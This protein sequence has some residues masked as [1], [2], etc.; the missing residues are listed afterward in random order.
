MWPDGQERPEGVR[1]EVEEPVLRCQPPHQVAHQLVPWPRCRSAGSDEIVRRLD[2][3]RLAQP[4]RPI[5]EVGGLAHVIIGKGGADEVIHAVTVALAGG[6]GGDGAGVEPVGE[7]VVRALGAL[8][9]GQPLRGVGPVVVARQ[10]EGL[11]TE[12]EAVGG[13][14][15]FRSAAHTGEEGR[16]LCGR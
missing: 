4:V 6:H 16:P 1:V 5:V 14:R 13:V 11:A 7:P 15:P 10:V 8:L 3:W 12:Q 2:V 9:V